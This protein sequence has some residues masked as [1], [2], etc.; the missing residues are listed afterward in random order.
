MEWPG[1]FD[2]FHRHVLPARLGGARGREAARDVRDAPALAFRVEDRS[3]RLRPGGD[4][5]DL[6]PGDDAPVLLELAAEAWRQLVSEMRTA[7]GLH[8]GRGLRFVRGGYADLERWEPALRALFQDRPIFDPTAPPPVADPTRA[9]DGDDDP[10][11]LRAFLQATGYLHVRAVFTAAE[12]AALAE[13]IARQQAAARPGDG[14]SW[15]AADAGGAALLCRLIYL[16]DASPAIAALG[17]DRRMRRLVALA[18][19]RL[20]LLVDRCDG[21][22]VVI[23]NGGA[24]DGLSD[25]P[26]HR[27]CGLGGHPVLCPG[28]NVGI[29]LDAA[30]PAS[31]QLHMIPGSWRA[32]CHR[33]DLV[34]ATSVALTTAPGDCTVHFG[35]VMHAAPPPAAAGPGRRTL[36]LSFAPPRLRDVVPVRKG[37][38]DVILARV[39]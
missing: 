25:L 38:N 23:K 16:A 12:I 35:D 37:F 24:V 3:W 28:V 34:R 9:F 4:V 8:Y 27:D 26:W 5:L 17:D 19:E 15:W 1:D 10:A 22:V 20:D 11:S 31:G 39:G 14:R 33:S 13:E 7:A 21:P 6:A 29:Q 36:Y 18:G 2:D 32:S 30:T